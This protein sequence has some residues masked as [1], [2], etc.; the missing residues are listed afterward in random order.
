MTDT[1]SMEVEDI[2]N[3]IT[4]K[5]N[6]MG[7]DEQKDSIPSKPVSS[8]ENILENGYQESDETI[9]R[10]M[11]HQFGT[12]SAAMS[13][14]GVFHVVKTFEGDPAK[15]K[16]WVKDIEKYS[17]LV[18]LSDSKIPNI[19]YQTSTGSVCD[20]IRRYLDTL[21]EEPSWNDLKKLL[22]QRF[23]EVTDAQQAM[24]LLRKTRQTDSESVQIFS[25]RILQV[26]EDAYPK[27]ET[28]DKSLVQQQLINA[29]IDGLSSDYIKMKVMRD[30]R[31]TFEEAVN[32]AMKEHNLRKR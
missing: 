19:A 5:I 14:Q 27:I 26:A 16:Q 28:K 21:D 30:D 29:F 24:A 32:I 25:E 9:L 13:T 6:V 7:I 15:F 8:G 17:K 18:Q 3:E 23:A 4:D 10:K 12:L 1:N 31:K 2:V 22:K 20:F 11:A